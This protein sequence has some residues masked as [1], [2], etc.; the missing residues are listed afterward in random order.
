[1]AEEQ[2]EI[3]RCYLTLRD[4]ESC[5]HSTINTP[6]TILIPCGILLSGLVKIKHYPIKQF[7]RQ[8]QTRFL[9]C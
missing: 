6:Y 2:E 8:E 4:E 7:K 5:Y 1:M 3:R 9:I